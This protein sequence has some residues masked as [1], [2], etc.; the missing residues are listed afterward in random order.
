LWTLQPFQCCAFAFVI[1]VG[2]P[3]L[4]I[5]PLSPASESGRPEA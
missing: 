2:L 5:R 1:P 4:T 3:A